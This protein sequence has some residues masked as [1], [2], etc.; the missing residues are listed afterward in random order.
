MVSQSPKEDCEC[1][2]SFLPE[3]WSPTLF[4]FLF[5]LFLPYQEEKS[6]FPEFCEEK[7]VLLCLHDQ[8]VGETT[9]SF[10]GDENFDTA[11]HRSR[12]R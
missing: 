3:W 7:E 5:S 2:S 1:P 11:F 12:Y 10:L 6:H 8:M 4:S 9:Q